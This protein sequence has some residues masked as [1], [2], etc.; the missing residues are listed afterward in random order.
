ML[1]LILV[2][3]EYDRDIL[4]LCF[5]DDIP[6]CIDVA[7]DRAAMARDRIRIL[8]VKASGREP[9]IRQDLVDAVAMVVVTM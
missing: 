5:G 1:D 2:V 4:F 8:A 6:E 7:P 3:Q 9:R